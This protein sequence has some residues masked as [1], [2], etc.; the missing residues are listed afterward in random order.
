MCSDGNRSLEAEAALA[1]VALPVPVPTLFTYVVPAG[2]EG[3]RPGA[4]VLCPLGSRRVVGVVVATRAG[5]APAKPKTIV[6]VVDD[7]A[8]AIPKELL[9]F[10]LELSRYYLAPVG[11]VVRLA[12]PA[13]P[14]AAMAAID[15]PDEP[16]LFPTKPRG[17]AVRRAQWVIA[18]APAIPT[19]PRL[20][21]Q[22]A[23]L[24][25]HLKTAI[26]AEVAALEKTWSNA[27]GA[28]ATLVRA[29]LA[30]IE[31][32][33]AVAEPFFS[34]SLPHEPAPTLT[35]AQRA[36]VARIETALGEG[37]PHTLVLHGVTGS[38]KT[39][40]YLSAIAAC[41]QRSRGA[42]VLVPEIALTPQ[43]VAR[44]RGR[45]GDDVAI[46]HSGLTPRERQGMWARL[47]GGELDVAIGARS[48]L[49][50]P[51][52]RLGLVIVDEEHD[53]SFK[54]EEGVRYH[55]R[56]MAILRAHRAGGLVV[57]G[58]A[59]PS[60]E[61][62]HLARTG[63]AE[64][65]RLPARARAQAMPVVE[66][67]DLRR[68]GAGPTGDKRLSLPLHRAIEETLAKR[69]QAIIFLNR[70]GF[71]PSVRC[72]ACGEL[73]AC[74]S[75][76][77]ALTFHKRRGGTLTCHYCGFTR[78]PTPACEKCGVSALVLEGLGTEK[79]EETL[80]LAFPS[81]RV[82]RLDRDVAA[83]ASARTVEAVMARV[84]RGEID[85]LVGTQM[86]TKGHDLPNVTLVGV[87]NA[88]AALSIPDFRASERGFQLLVQVAG[89]AGRGDVG[90]RARVLIQ[91]YDPEQSAIVFAARHDVDGF[92]ERE[93]ANRAE[94]GYPPFSRMVLVRVEAIAAEDARRAA[95]WLAEVATGEKNR[96][97]D[98]LGPAEAPLARLR[99][100]FR[101]RVMLRAA[102]RKA[103]RQVTLVLEHRRRELP[104]KVRVVIDVDP[105]QLL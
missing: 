10:L 6:S 58:S 19:A 65:L 18:V 64:K 52:A 31:E 57:L 73:A 38:G 48:A 89:R 24:W 80:A 7:G 32:R 22:T 16:S 99:N 85:I 69:E 60:L 71:A 15:E 79:L 66:S 49:F 50:A 2:L 84:R 39:E 40:V 51:V 75:C 20:R 96:L 95:A 86:V 77:V 35:E 90:Q 26:E 25:E 92:L 74:P 98:V 88:D 67:V 63:R 1:D 78:P 56:D 34:E 102:D 36:A 12:L 11:E 83:G 72:Q 62:E 101:Y 104:S 44:Y 82:A 30:R 3:V 28:A 33:D 17:L 59:T 37:K 21:G 105:V 14:R 27:R 103:L 5:T 91:T 13:V 93:L 68:M 97:V 4:R 46:L 43:L 81:A 100:R 47:H 76:S 42:L 45:F 41:R 70:R 94:L 29:G 61:T 8:P 87:I 55:A 54:Q 9:D 53:S 23:L